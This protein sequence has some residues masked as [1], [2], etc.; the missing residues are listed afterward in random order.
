MTT[1]TGMT[2]APPTS[3]AVMGLPP[4]GRGAQWRWAKPAQ[5]PGVT[6]FR[7]SSVLTVTRAIARHR[8]HLR[9]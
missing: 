7:P 6:G 8:H 1:S 4:P 5:P 9:R 2:P 3:P